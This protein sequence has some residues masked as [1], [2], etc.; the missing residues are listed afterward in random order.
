MDANQQDSSLI[1]QPSSLNRWGRFILGTLLV[2][3]GLTT[4]ILT[5]MAKQ[6]GVPELTSA[7]AIASLIFVLLITL[8]VVPPLTRSAFAEIAVNGLPLEVT[9]GG[10]IFVVILII[11][12]FA[13]WNTGNNLLFMVLSIMLSTIFVSWAAARMSLRDLNVSAR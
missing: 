7:G 12:G 8:L 3:A 13:A 10:V 5:L 6:I 1:P 11:V 2:L 4:A 9:T